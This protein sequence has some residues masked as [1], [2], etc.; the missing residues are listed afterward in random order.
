MESWSRLEIL[1]VAL[2]QPAGAEAECISFLLAVM[3]LDREGN[4]ANNI[5]FWGSMGNN[6]ND[7]SKITPKVPIDPV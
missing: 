1:D 2:R 6:L 4:E 3:E 7:A 5:P